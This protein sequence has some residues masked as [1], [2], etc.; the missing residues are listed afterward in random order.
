MA[1]FLPGDDERSVHHTPTPPGKVIVP[2]EEAVST[3]IHGTWGWRGGW[4]R[5]RSGDFHTFILNSHRPNLYSGGA[6]YSWSGRYNVGDR[7]LAVSDFCAWAGEP[8]VAGQG[9]QTLFAHSYGGEVA[10]R[11]ALA[12]A[13]VSELVLLSVPVNRHIR[14]VITDRPGIRVVDVRLRLDPVLALARNIR[15]RVP[16]GPNVASVLLK[17]WRLDHGATHKEHVWKKEA[18]A[19]LGQI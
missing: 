13:Q 16:P 11:A 4:W 19:E 12:G 18:I 6:T 17:F 8:A 7:R 3:M 5:P 2:P 1:A 9:I 14:K 10:V 15:Q